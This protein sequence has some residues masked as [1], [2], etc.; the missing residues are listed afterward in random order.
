MK[1]PTSVIPG[2]AAQAAEGATLD[3]YKDAVQPHIDEPV[4]A[5]CLFSRQGLMSEKAAGKFGALSYM[6]ARKRSEMRAG[7]LP[8]H[9]ILAVTDE[10]VYAFETKVGMRNPNGAGDVRDEVARWERSALRVSSSPTKSTGGLTI[11]VTL[12]SP[13]E[14]ETVQCSVGKHPLSEDFLRLLSDPTAKA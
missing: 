14:G 12:E 4:I 8:Q 7:G 10:R 6:G 5:A 2:R 9:F 3:I 13:D 1:F 11:N